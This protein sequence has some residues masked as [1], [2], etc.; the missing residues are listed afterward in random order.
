PSVIPPGTGK[1]S[2]TF[3]DFFFLRFKN[4]PSTG[5]AK[6]FHLTILIDHVKIPSQ[7]PR[8]TAKGSEIKKQIISALED[9]IVPRAFHTR[10][11]DLGGI[12]DN[13]L[14]ME[15]APARIHEQ[16]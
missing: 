10:I 1:R 12:W 9:R 2:E 7:Q 16:E 4:I 15:K 11:W 3:G 8:T 6:T 13:T 14:I 5:Q